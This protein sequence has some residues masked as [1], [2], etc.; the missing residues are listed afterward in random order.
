MAGGPTGG[1]FAVM[2]RSIACDTDRLRDRIT[3]VLDDDL[4]GL[5]GEAWRCHNSRRYRPAPS[6]SRR[7]TDPLS[8][9]VRVRPASVWLTWA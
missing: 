6:P 1:G 7:Y 5:L 4:V 3:A 2:S 9:K 8:E